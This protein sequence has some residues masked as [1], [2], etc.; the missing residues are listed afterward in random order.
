MRLDI[1]P[2]GILE[3]AA[4]ALGVVPGPLV[5]G[6]WGMGASRTLIIASRLGVFDA[7]AAGPKTAGEVAAATDCHPEG[8]ECLLDALNGFGFVKHR[9]RR[10]RNAR[11]SRKWL[12]RD[13]R[14]SVQLVFHFFDY[15]WDSI[16][17]IESGVRTGVPEDFHRPGRPEE[18]W[19]TYTRSFAKFA[20]YISKEIVRRVRLPRPPARL[21]DVG[22]GHGMYAGA[23]VERYPGLVAEV[24]DLPQAAESGRRVAAEAGLADR[25][26]FRSGDMHAVEW[27]DG[28]DVVLLFNVLHN[29]SRER[30]E[31][32]IRRA[33]YSLAAGGKLVVL[34]SEHRVRR[35]N[36]STASG[37]NELFFFAVN[38]TRPWPE[39]TIQ[40]WMQ[41]A[42]F[43]DVRRRRL[44]SMPA[45]VLFTAERGK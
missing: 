40:T 8:M 17:A 2:Q 14:H 23:F 44:F 7:L 22:G 39:G 32:T 18:F 31:I 41:R 24:I 25:I 11:S 26:S 5:L 4:F 3:R 28:Y 16:T 9:K 15:L 20:G 37:F 13:S 33:R 19:E 12:L 1:V 29:M 21:L 36:L 42:G 35:G 38:G 43:C 10:Y 30:A 6:F 45:G 34:D 27:G